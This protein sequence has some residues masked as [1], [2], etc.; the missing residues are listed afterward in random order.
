VRWDPRKHP[1]LN[2]RTH[3]AWQSNP[4]TFVPGLALKH[5]VRRGPI[6]VYVSGSIKQYPCDKNKCDSV[7]VK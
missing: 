6:N 2:L 1:Y 4:M 7:G 3:A 5:N